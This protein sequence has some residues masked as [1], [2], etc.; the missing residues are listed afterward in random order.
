[1]SRFVFKVDH[2]NYI[3]TIGSVILS[4]L[5]ILMIASNYSI[6]LFNNYYELTENEGIILIFLLMIVVILNF[7]NIIF[8]LSKKA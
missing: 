3:V 6:G 2:V 1:M 4:A 5:G 7:V 8:K